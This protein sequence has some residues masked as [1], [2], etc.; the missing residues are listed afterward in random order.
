MDRFV[1]ISPC[2]N[3]EN[4]IAV[5]LSQLEK[6]FD[7]TTHEFTVVMVDD[8]STD[9]SVRIMKEFRFQ[10]DRNQLK[11]LRLNRNVGH[12]EAIKQGFRYACTIDAIGYIVIDS[13]GEDN[14][15]VILT[16][17]ERRT[18]EIIFITRG[19]RSESLSFKMGYLL[20]KLL[21]RLISG[22]KINFGNYSMVNKKVVEAIVS[23]NFQHFSAFLSK[24]KFSKEFIK[25]DRCK[26]IGGKSKMTFSDLV[27]HGL[28]SLTE[29]SEELLFFFI[30][31]LSFIILIFILVGIYAIYSKFINHT[32]IPGW[33]SNILLGL[34]N[35]ILIIT[36]IIVLGLLIL[37]QKDQ[38]LSKECACTEIEN[39]S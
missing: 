28:K 18:S 16:L 26:R 37:S 34:V 1:V 31:I 5:F 10:T 22:T 33:T 27:F 30:R 13:D 23:S 8:C 21:F 39:N 6:T 29:Y 3:E 20:Y 24:L 12:Q 11:I 25:S 35:S 32:A 14:P 38:K 19:H 36:G 15:E 2:Y 7:K 17:I 9:S 4:T